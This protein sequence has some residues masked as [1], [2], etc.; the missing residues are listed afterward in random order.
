MSIAAGIL[1]YFGTFVK[2]NI[3]D[4]IVGLL[5]FHWTASTYMLQNHSSFIFLV[6]QGV[7]K[8]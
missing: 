4:A 6:I 3:W 2:Y 5:L 8:M 1:N 7:L